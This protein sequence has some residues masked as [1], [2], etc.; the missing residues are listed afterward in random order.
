[1]EKQAV[2][3]KTR[4]KDN[5]DCMDKRPNF[6][7]TTFENTANQLINEGFKLINK[8]GNQWTF[9]NDKKKNFSGKEGIVETNHLYL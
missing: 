9:L 5:G 7:M 2:I 1:M 4:P 8:S 6:I 3:R